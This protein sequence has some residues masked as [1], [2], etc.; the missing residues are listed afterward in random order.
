MRRYFF[1]ARIACALVFVA[2]PNNVTGVQPPPEEIIPL[3]DIWAHRMPGTRDIRELEPELDPKR[4]ETLPYEKRLELRQNALW[5]PIETSLIESSIR[6]RADQSART[7][8]AVAGTGIEALRK[9]HAVLVQGEKPRTSLSTNEDLLL[10]FFSFP[11]DGY[12]VHLHQVNRR[13]DEI[14]LQYQLEPYA[15]RVLSISFALIPIGILPVGEYNVEMTQIPTK[16]E[17]V[18][19]GY[20][21]IDENWTRQFLCKRFSFRVVEEHAE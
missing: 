3:K 14:E 17:F 20:K 12:R 16:Q 19:L 7:G 18:A 15:E 5:E 1:C 11:S 2:Q 21:R 8:F 4:W 13:D 6:P 9:A 10:I